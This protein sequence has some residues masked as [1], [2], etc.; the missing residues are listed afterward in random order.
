M[1]KEA[2]IKILRREH[3]TAVDKFDFDG[4]E[5]IQVQINR[6]RAE[7]AREFEVE[8]TDLLYL[9]LDEEKMRIQ[10]D[11][12]QVHSYLIQKRIDLQQRFHR[13]YSRLQ[14]LQTQAVAALSLQYTTNLERELLRPVPEAETLFAEAKL[15]G[16]A[17]QY[18]AARAAYQKAAEIRDRANEE[19]R[20]TCGEIY[21]HAQARLKEKHERELQLLAE[22]QEVAL[23]KIESRMTNNKELVTSRIRTSEIR[24]TNASRS[25]VRRME[26]PRRTTSAPLSNTPNR[27]A[28]SA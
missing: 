2:Q 21:G 23:R 22:K 24:H 17:H 3:E 26:S 7:R 6:L 14:E 10:D 5:L 9:D 12:A 15:L 19:K 11:S 1:D 28:L 4:A 13:R 18:A 8:T 27:N 20:Q 16:R 25:R